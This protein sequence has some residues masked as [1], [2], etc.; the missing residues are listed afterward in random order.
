MRILQ[1][2]LVLRVACLISYFNRGGEQRKKD[3]YCGQSLGGGER[4][5]RAGNGTGWGRLSIF[6]CLFQ[7]GAKNRRS[8][9]LAP[10]GAK[11][12]SL[13]EEQVLRLTD[14]QT[15]KQKQTIENRNEQ[16]RAKMGKKWENITSLVTCPL[17][18]HYSAVSSVSS[19]CFS[20]S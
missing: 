2:D 13:R 3:R 15:N 20:W 18:A 7:G 16:K 6:V 17:S 11:G 14:K 5:S 1:P 8:V 9:S 12:S 19:A 4:K 10:F